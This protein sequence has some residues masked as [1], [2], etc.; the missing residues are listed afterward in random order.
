VK[1]SI[2]FLLGS[3]ALIAFVSEMLV[4]S[5]EHAAGSLGMTNLFVGVVVVAIIGNAAEHSTAILVALKNRMDLSLSIAIGRLRQS[6]QLDGEVHQPKNEE[7]AVEKTRPARQQ[8]P[9]LVGCHVGAAIQTIPTAGRSTGCWQW[10]RQRNS[11]SRM[12][13]NRTSGLMRGGSQ[14][15][16]GAST[17]QPVGSRL[18]YTERV[19]LQRAHHFVAAPGDSN[20]LPATSRSFSRSAG[21]GP[22]SDTTNGGTRR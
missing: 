5:V 3:T 21:A 8:I 6:L 4:A 10:F 9:A 1:K 22:P 11:E 17:S 13:E 15:V 2:A 20:P 14:T 7:L 18:L 19:V 16:M 12:R